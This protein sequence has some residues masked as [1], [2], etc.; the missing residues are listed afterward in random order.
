MKRPGEAVWRERVARQKRSGKTVAA[1]CRAEGVSHA[2]FYKWRQRLGLTM[3]E[4]ASLSFVEVS[5]TVAPMFEVVL[6]SGVL[7]RVPGQYDPTVQHP[8]P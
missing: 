2:S 7:V 8:R 1:F 4:P 3:A 6:T 5:P